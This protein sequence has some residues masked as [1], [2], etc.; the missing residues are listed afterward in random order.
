MPVAAAALVFAG[1][2][3]AAA[4][5]PPPDARLVILICDD[6]LRADYLTRFAPHF[7][8]G[9][10][11][12][13]ME[14]GAHFVNAYV[15]YAA[16]ETAPGHAT[17]STGRLPRQHGIVG[18]KW[19]HKPGE[20]KP[21][22][23]VDD[24]DVRLVGAGELDG[25]GQSPN[26]LIGPAIGDQMKLADRRS[27][28]F[29]VALK[30]R[31]AIFLAGK[32]PDGVFWCDNPTGR[33]VSSTYYMDELPAY[34]LAINEAG[35]AWRY[36]GRTWDRLLP[37]DAYAGAYAVSADWSSVLPTLGA[38]FPHRLPDAPDKPEAHFSELVFGT[39]LG[40][41]LV[42]EVAQTI[43]EHE[44]LGL[45]PAPDLL[46]VGLSANDYVGHFFG[47]DSAE[48]IDVTVRTDRQLAAFFKWLDQRVGLSRCLIVL[49]ADHGT[50]S[51]P[52]V[53]RQ[54]N[55][56][57]GLVNLGKIAAELNQIMHERLPDVKSDQPLVLGV[58][59]PWV[60]CDPSFEELDARLDG[61]LT[62][63]AVEYLNR[64]P[65]IAAAFPARELAGPPPAPDDLD[66]WL[67]WRSYHAQRSG[68]FFLKLT[69]GWF[70]TDKEDIAGHSC[71]FLSDRHVPI[72][73]AGPQVRPGRRFEPADLTDI[74]VTLAALLGIEAPAEA[75]GRVLH[76][77]I[78]PAAH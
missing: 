8:A 33:M 9:G 21:Q 18:N 47:P 58:S 50:S 17:I 4:A 28:V 78:V 11:R 54:L 71:G 38:A 7:E 35:G 31:A 24:P 64:V 6:Q 45:G 70:H 40:N 49:T 46:C 69:P 22:Q 30:D 56:Y 66:R 42:L 44:G 41:E 55:L 77:A 13:L 5:P 63:V 65:G 74:A 39:P 43:V 57:K 15:S 14:N 3:V 60:Y 26:A 2:L 76:E 61:E 34:L 67:A 10:F 62:R 52:H 12:W 75:T 1:A 68:R 51:T 20:M 25:G 29:S 16:S 72:L 59:L 27:R 37:E 53:A 36:A 73:I 32:K 48:V 19:Y 23:P